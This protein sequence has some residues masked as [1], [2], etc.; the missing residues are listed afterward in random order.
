MG[1]NLIY[2]KKIK[3]GHTR[4]AT[5]RFVRRRDGIRKNGNFVCSDNYFATRNYIAETDLF[6]SVPAIKKKLSSRN[7]LAC[8]FLVWGVGLENILMCFKYN[9]N[10]NPLGNQNALFELCRFQENDQWY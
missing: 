10:K 4:G 2:L 1:S 6:E 8:V 9:L 7:V 3:N 5:Y